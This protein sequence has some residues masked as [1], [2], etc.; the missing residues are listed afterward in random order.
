MAE[1][2]Y[3]AIVATPGFALGVR[4][5]DEEIIEIEFLEPRPE[6]APANPLAAEAV[7]QLHAYLADPAFQFGLPLRPSGTTFQRRVWGEIAAIPAGVT[8]TYG[9]VAKNLRNAPRAVG[10]ACG[11]NPFPLVVPCH[12]VVASGGGLGGFARH[13]GGFLLDIKRWLLQ[14]EGRGFA[15]TRG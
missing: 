15:G 12:R 13:G 11:A 8:L 7:R 2:S 1:A 6:Q 14:H 3:Q 5:D 10:Q 9:E 4:C